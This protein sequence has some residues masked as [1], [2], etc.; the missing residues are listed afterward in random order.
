MTVGL[1]LTGFVGIGQ[2]SA[3]GTG[4]VRTNFYEIN[5]E[6][7]AVE[8]NKIESAAL[9]AVGIRESKVAQGGISVGGD[10]SYDVQYAGCERLFKHGFGRIA[11]LQPDV[12]TYPQV[13][14]HQFTIA[15]D[16]P[17]GMTVEVFR[18]TEQFATEPDK[19][20]LYTGCR[21]TNINLSCGVDDLLKMTVS[22]MGR[23]EGRVDKSTPSY[24]PAE[25][26]VYHQ[27]TVRWDGGDVECEQFNID[28]ANALE[29]RPRLGSRFSR[30]PKRSGKLSVSGSFTAEFTGWREYDDF[31]N[32]TSREMTLVFEGPN[33]GGAFYH[34]ITITMTVAKILG[35]RVVLAQPGRLMMEVQFKAY[36]TDNAGE[37]TLVMRNTTTGS[38]AN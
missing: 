19:S 16:L 8:E 3:Y 25:L 28:I 35:H 18:G 30:Q 14:D 21:M 13:W 27:G 15:D 9:A 1:G 12:T 38:L 26:A 24:N 20:F 7:M 4:A 6:S 22:L 33:I 23:D 32:N 2:E 34:R 31:R 11:S 10:F 5:D 36:R 29:S 17:E 37:I